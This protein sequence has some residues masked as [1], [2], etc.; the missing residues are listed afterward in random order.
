MVVIVLL[1]IM[2]RVPRYRMF[3]TKHL[4]LFNFWVLLSGW[5]YA[6]ET[7]KN[8]AKILFIWQEKFLTNLLQSIETNLYAS[9]LPSIET[10]LYAS[11]L[12]LLWHFS[13]KALP[14][15]DMLGKARKDGKNKSSLRRENVLS[16]FVSTKVN[17]S[18]S[19]NKT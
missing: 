10:N 14:E 4:F 18:P 17:L 6:W 1:E 7:R 9:L 3:L 19:V 16:C 2:N 8:S 13:Y 12:F 15:F 11:F 5:I